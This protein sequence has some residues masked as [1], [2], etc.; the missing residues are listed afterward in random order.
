MKPKK[1]AAPEPNAKSDDASALDEELL[2]LSR[3]N[4]ELHRVNVDFPKWVVNTIDVEARRQGVTRQS[5]IKM[6]IVDH[7]DKLPEARP[8]E[9]PAAEPPTAAAGS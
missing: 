4:R 7:L 1:A 5:L 8:A 2:T 6:W 9:Q 3:T